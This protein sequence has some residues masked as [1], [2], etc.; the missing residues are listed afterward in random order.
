MLA[1]LL[2]SATAH[3]GGLGRPNQMSARGVGMGGAWVAFVDDATA[4]WFNPAAMTEIDPQVQVGAEVVVGPRSYTPVAD[5][6]TRGAPQEATVFAPVPALGGVGRFTYNDRP[7]WFTLGGGVWNTYGG[8]VSY[9]KTNMPALDSTQDAVIEAQVGTGL[10]LSD[11]FSIGA[12]FRFGIGL[13]AVQGTRMPYDSDLSA[14]GIGVSHLW[15]LHFRPTSKVKVGVVWRAPMNLTTTGSGTVDGASGLERV[16]V[17]HEQQWPQSAALGVGLQATPE[18]RLA[19]QLDW[20]Q[21]ST[22]K[23]LVV[24]LPG[25]GNPDQIYREDWRDSWTVRLGAEYAVSKAV[26]VR[27]GG[28]YDTEAVIDRSK[29]RQY[30]DSNKIGLA[31]GGSFRIGG[32]WRIDAAVDYIIPRTHTVKQNTPT[33]PD[34]ERNKAPGDYRGTLV[35]IEASVARVF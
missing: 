34:Y 5:D 23:A 18:L 27:A 2:L 28:Y 22:V 4:V 6:G 25:S 26:A 8:Q 7:S 21:W 9:P 17:E 19:T 13:F 35:T 15:S 24:K 11:K 30:V 1:T 12:S 32:K 29:E 3:A 10:R 20:V 31:A 33:T 16:S 14:S